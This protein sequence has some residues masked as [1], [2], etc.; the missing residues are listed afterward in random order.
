MHETHRF[1]V[2]LLF[3]ASYTL[4]MVGQFGYTIPMVG[5]FG[6]C[7]LL[8]S[9]Y[10]IHMVGQFWNVCGVSYTLLLS[11]YKLI[12]SCYGV[13]GMCVFLGSLISFFSVIATSLRY[14]C[15]YCLLSSLLS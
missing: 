3:K 4:H 14:F 15:F 8:K 6:V 9:S 11:V 12:Q 13:S 10:T 1:D 2:C 7:L 5:Q